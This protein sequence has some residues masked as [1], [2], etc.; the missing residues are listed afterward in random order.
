MELYRIVQRMMDF[1][2]KTKDDKMSCV[3][4]RI[5]HRLAHQGA[6][7]EKPLTKFELD[8]VKKFV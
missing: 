3:V 6:I 1:A 2:A 7:C 8:V 5:A 4:S